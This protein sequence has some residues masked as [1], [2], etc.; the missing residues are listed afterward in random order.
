MA[1]AAAVAGWV[2]DA[3][4]P[5][6]DDRVTATAV[7]LSTGKNPTDS[8]GVWQLPGAPSGDGPAQARHAL[9]VRGQ[10]AGWGAFPTHRSG[11]W[12]LYIP[13]AGAAVAAVSVGREGGKVADKVTELPDAAG[14][15]AQGL[16]EGIGLAGDAFT[17]I[18]GLAGFLLD[19]RSWV[20][21]SKVVAGLV[22]GFLGIAAITKTAAIDPITRAL[23][24]LDDFIGES[25]GDNGRV[26]PI[27]FKT[28]GPA[29][30]AKSPKLGGSHA[31]P[32]KP[33]KAV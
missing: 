13:T 17:G 29:P 31:P 16:T 12:A 28:K 20:R 18:A 21:V 26:S 10:P 5:G 11:R 2:I 4:W 30:A 24:S 6:A 33:R 32:P 25:I 3:G 22:L 14:A 27:T 15:A 8:G 19:R 7:G 23:G 9:S 1:T